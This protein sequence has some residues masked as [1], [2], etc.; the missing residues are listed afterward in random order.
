MW[1]YQREDEHSPNTARPHLSR[2]QVMSRDPQGPTERSLCLSGWWFSMTSVRRSDDCIWRASW[3]RLKIGLPTHSPRNHL[4]P[5][6]Q[7]LSGL[8]RPSDVHVCPFQELSEFNGQAHHSH[9]NSELPGYECSSLLQV[10]CS[11]AELQRPFIW[12]PPTSVNPQDG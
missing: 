6:Q 4:M 11:S 9:P 2:V 1:G 10:S 5:L 8:R 12:K 3:K 7:D